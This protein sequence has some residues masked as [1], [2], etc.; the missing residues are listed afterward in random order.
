MEE[1]KNSVMN[2][3]QN[4]WESNILSLKAKANTNT[5]MK[6]EKEF[7]AFKLQWGKYEFALPVPT[8][9]SG[10]ADP[11]PRVPVEQTALQGGAVTEHLVGLHSILLWVS[12]CIQDDKDHTLVETSW[13]GNKSFKKKQRGI[14]FSVGNK[15][16]LVSEIIP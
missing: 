14:R 4:A 16:T 1:S 2:V 6:T 12:S 13:T 11:D 9:G 8:L 10:A 3:C 7:L 5:K 15:S